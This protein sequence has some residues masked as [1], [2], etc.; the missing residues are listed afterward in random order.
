MTEG[1][2]K[3]YTLY[4]GVSML[5]KQV[6]FY[7]VS[8]VPGGPANA[9]I[10]CILVGKTTEKSIWIGKTRYPKR[11]D[12]VNFFTSYAEAYRFICT[13]QSKYLV[14]MHKKYLASK[15]NLEAI[16]LLRRD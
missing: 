14:S 13:H 6:H 12:R 10:D 2:S 4:I 11:T 7:K 8:V 16:K 15:A 9:R 3:Q 1:Y 5:N